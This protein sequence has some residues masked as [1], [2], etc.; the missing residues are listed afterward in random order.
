[1]TFPGADLEFILLKYSVTTF[2]RT[3]PKSNF[4]KS[5]GIRFTSESQ[6]EKWLWIKFL[7]ILVSMKFKLLSIEEKKF[8]NAWTKSWVEWILLFLLEGKDT[9]MLSFLFGLGNG[10]SFCQN[11]LIEAEFAL[12]KSL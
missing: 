2:S 1:M 7:Q 3:T 8:E 9:L 5:L 4:D 10:F 11:V 12:T 6:L